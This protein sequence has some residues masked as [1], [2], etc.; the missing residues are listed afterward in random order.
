VQ[1][2][3]NVRVKYFTRH[4]LCVEMFNIVS[5]LIHHPKMSHRIKTTP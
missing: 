5:H 1:A 3:L 2:D 4:Q